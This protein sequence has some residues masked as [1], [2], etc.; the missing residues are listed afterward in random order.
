MNCTICCVKNGEKMLHF[1]GIEFLHW[2][3]HLKGHI[4]GGVSVYCY[5]S[6]KPSLSTTP[7][8]LEVDVGV[9]ILHT[10]KREK[11]PALLKRFLPM[12]LCREIDERVGLD[13]IEEIRL[14]AD[15]RVAL[16]TNR[17]NIFLSCIL[18]QKEISEIL[19]E[20]CGHSLYAY[21]D[22][23]NNGY[24]TLDGGIRVGVCGRA[25]IEDERII[26][27][28]GISSL[29]IRIP[30]DVRGVGGEIC[31]LLRGM[32]TARGVLIYSPPGVGK[33]TPLRSVALMMGSGADALRVAIIDTRGELSC[34]ADSQSAAIDVLLGYPKGIGIEIAARTMNAELMVC[35]EIGEEREVRS[36]LYAQNCGVPLLASAHGDG[37]DGLL[38]RRGILELH[39]AGVFGAYVGIS[40]K[41][42]SPM[43]NYKITT[44]EEADDILQNSGS[45]D[46][47]DQRRALGGASERRT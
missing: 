34:F 19:A 36:I 15:R 3:N 8:H 14:R 12:T 23:I 9:S 30:S 1:D 33:T 38:R 5:R 7:W 44:S 43:Y 6:K 40:R 47:V 45:A 22:M 4:F 27:V 10:E 39:R 31:R 20:M 25:A 41:D 35:D 11:Y 18:S 16:T 29:N 28:Y 21:S 37:I 24:V 42:G 46:S 32:P 13:N 26:G 17:G 2:E